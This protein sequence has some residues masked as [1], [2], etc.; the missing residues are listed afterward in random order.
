M[1]DDTHME[2]RELDAQV[3]AASEDAFPIKL[4]PRGDSTLPE[5]ELHEHLYTHK[6]TNLHTR[7]APTR[8]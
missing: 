5:I 1:P 8:S 7:N 2:L 4:I 6:R 3:A